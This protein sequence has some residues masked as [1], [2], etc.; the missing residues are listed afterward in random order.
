MQTSNVAAW[1]MH[2]RQVYACQAGVT[3]TLAARLSSLST[4]RTF[5]LLIALL[6]LMDPSRGVRWFLQ[7]L[8]VDQSATPKKGRAIAN[9]FMLAP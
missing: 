5:F 9:S 4:R 3:V 7:H 1:C 2:A 6:L 8:H